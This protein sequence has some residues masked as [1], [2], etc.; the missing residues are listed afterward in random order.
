[1]DEYPTYAKLQLQRETID[2]LRQQVTQLQDAIR[3]HK[4]A[5]LNDLPRHQDHTLW[6]HTP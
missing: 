2:Q 6:A 5:T 3:R 1:M 4:I